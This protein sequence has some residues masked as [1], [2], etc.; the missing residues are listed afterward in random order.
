MKIKILDSFSIKLADQV[1]YIAQDKPQAARNFKKEVF[2]AIKSL[3]DMPYKNRKS[4]YFSDDNV[5]DL[6]YKSYKIVYR[7][8]PSD[9]IIEVFGLI[10]EEEKL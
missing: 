3:I 1:E 4:T 5:R 7:I 2:K 9:E 6:I 10:K 8:K